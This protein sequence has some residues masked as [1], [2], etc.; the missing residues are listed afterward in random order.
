MFHETELFLRDLPFLLFGGG[1]T[2]LQGGRV[3]DNQGKGFR[4]TND[5]WMACAKPFG[6]RDFKLGE[7]GQHTVAIEGLFA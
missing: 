5:L 1:D 7:D 3:W 2:G 6:L 4:S